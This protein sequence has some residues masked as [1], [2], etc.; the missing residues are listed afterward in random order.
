MITQYK[1]ALKQGISSM[2]PLKK[3]ELDTIVEQFKFQE[4]AKHGHLLT[5]GQISKRFY[6]IIDGLVRVYYLQD[7]KEVTTFLATNNCFVTS[8]V[9]FIRQVRSDD[10]IQ[11]LEDTVVASVSYDKMQELYEQIPVWNAVT[12]QFMEQ[13]LL[14]LSERFLK[15]HNVKARDKYLK[16][17]STNPARIVQRTPIQ[18]IAS[19]L[20]ITPESLSRIRRE[21]AAEA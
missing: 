4:I 6:F 16:F 2:L 8:P 3:E 9:S 18:H 12:R 17:I 10:Y 19:F 1:N 7:D 20:G 14:C 11:C 21:L 13:N 15:Q 5:G